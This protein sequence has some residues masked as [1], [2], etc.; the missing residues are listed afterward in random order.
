MARGSNREWIGL[1]QPARPWRLTGRQASAYALATG[2]EN[3]RY[4]GVAPDAPPMAI[5]IGTVGVALRAIFEDEAFVGSHER[6]LRLVQTEEDIR[7]HR[8]LLVDEELRL[9]TT[10]V[11]ID[12]R[13]VG[14]ILSCETEVR[15][16]N[17]EHLATALTTALVRDPKPM[18]ERIAGLRKHTE[19]PAAL[20]ASV[21][22][23]LTSDWTVAPDQAE[24]YAEASG[25]RNPIHLDDAVARHAGLKG[26][27]LHG[28]CTMA[29][30][31]RV[32]VD[33]VAGGV[34]SRLKRLR[35]RFSRPVYLG[36]TLTCALQPVSIDGH[37]RVTV[38]NQDGVSVLKD[39]IAE[40]QGDA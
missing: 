22:E 40:V 3:R 17:G 18:G 23:P 19:E 36:D 30:A 34:P 16:E 1:A 5:V 15:R 31:Q 24:R 12:D 10:V 35:V 25:D 29:F 11:D 32:I 7:W 27:I 9:V 28:L 33:R 4:Q 20:A 13:S 14:E 37:Y 6:F 2:D 38:Q 26:R 8:P 39:G 21:G